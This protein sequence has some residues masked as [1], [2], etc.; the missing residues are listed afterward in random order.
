M[1][2]AGVARGH[3]VPGI[4]V[5][6]PVADRLE[7]ESRSRQAVP[8]DGRRRV[9]RGQGTRMPNRVDADRQESRTRTVSQADTDEPPTTLPRE[10]YEG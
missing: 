3:P 7:D 5:A 6:Q 10:D 1:Y 9:A 4:D 8:G 2:G